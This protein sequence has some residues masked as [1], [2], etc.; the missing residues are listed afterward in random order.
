MMDVKNTKSAE[1]QQKQLEDEIELLA[2]NIA[3]KRERLKVL[4]DSSD[5]WDAKLA[6]SIFSYN[7]LFAYFLT[8]LDEYAGKEGTDSFF[9]NVFRQTIFRESNP[10]LH[11]MKKKVIKRKYLLLK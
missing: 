8:K 6:Q 4:M 10:Y 1:E 11:G 9:L 2:K 3:E 5:V 7:K